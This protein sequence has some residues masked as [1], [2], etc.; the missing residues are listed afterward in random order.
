MGKHMRAP[1]SRS[2]WLKIMPFKSWK[3]SW[4][5]IVQC[6]PEYE[7]FHLYNKILLY[8]E[9]WDRNKVNH[10]RRHFFSAS[11][12]RW[13]ILVLKDLWTLPSLK[14]REQFSIHQSL[15]H[16]MFCG[17]LMCCIDFLWLCTIYGNIGFS[18]HSDIK[19]AFNVNNWIDSKK[20]SVYV[21]D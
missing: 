8:L 20:N 1:P 14:K 18:I 6:C 15:H 17:Y 12:G 11:R 16:T 3:H 7:V 5:H 9:H 19:L 4:G 13:L 2:H 21:M 10:R